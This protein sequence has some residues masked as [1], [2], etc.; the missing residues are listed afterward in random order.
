VAFRD[1]RIIKWDGESHDDRVIRL[2]QL[3]RVATT[4]ADN[5]RA[6]DQALRPEEPD[7]RSSS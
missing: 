2:A 6:V 3:G 7:R 5:L 1:L 4:R